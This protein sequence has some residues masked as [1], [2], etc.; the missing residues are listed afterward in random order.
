[1]IP[2]IALS[3]FMS[4]Q[5]PVLAEVLDAPS[6]DWYQ[7]NSMMIG[8]GIYFVGTD[9]TP[10]SYGIRCDSS[11]YGMAIIVF[12]TEDA[13]YAYHHSSRFTVGEEDDA[14]EAN[15]SQYQYIYEEDTIALNL[16]EGNVLRIKGGIGELLSSDPNVTNDVETQIGNT[17]NLFEGNYVVGKDINTGGY[18]ITA[19]GD[20][21]TRFVVF[22]SEQKLADFDAADHFT[23][24]EFGADVEQNAMMDIYVD[25]GEQCYINLQEGMV[26]MLNNGTGTAQEVKMAWAK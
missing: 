21:G 1:M 18:M 6:T 22:E 26:L 24:G 11:K 8:E 13:Y 15:A 9:I 2:L 7:E 17:T 16:H 5:T 12:D 4:L 23:N 10:A 3:V 19:T 14:I 20:Y 25:K